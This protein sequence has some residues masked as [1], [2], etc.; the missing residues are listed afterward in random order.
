LTA[1]QTGRNLTI[2]PFGDSITFGIGSSDGNGYRNVLH[3]LLDARSNAVN[4]IGS[5]KAGTMADNDN[6]GHSG[7]TISQ[8]ANDA[9]T[10]SSLAQ[11]PNVVLLHIGTNDMNLN[12]DTANAP[13]RLGSLIDQIFT[14]TPDAVLIVA[15][16][17]A[18]TLASTQSLIATYNA[19]VPGVVAT[20]RNAGKKVLVVDMGSLLTSSDMSDFLHPNNQGYSKM[21]N[22]WSTALQ[23]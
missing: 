5:I 11:R 13:T 18:S 3:G 8:L 19:A 9:G 14:A 16:I 6:E 12:S 21:A 20:R 2:L 22:A 10:R 1:R 7:F 23:S 4:M 15:Q 17:I